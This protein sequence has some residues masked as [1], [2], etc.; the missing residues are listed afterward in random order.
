MRKIIIVLLIATMAL[1]GIPAFAET[2]KS[3]DIHFPCDKEELTV[4]TEGK[5]DAPHIVTLRGTKE[6][7]RNVD[8][9]IRLKD[10]KGG[11]A[12]PAIDEFD[13][14]KNTEVA[15]EHW[16]GFEN[17]IRYT[18]DCEDFAESQFT[19]PIAGG[20]NEADDMLTSVIIVDKLESRTKA[21]SWSATT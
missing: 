10:L 17:V 19:V 16:N 13:H 1:A 6:A 7:C 15:Q 20:D 8:I 5:V 3:G 4:T 2:F 12:F 11:E 9:T 21:P 14:L 18:A